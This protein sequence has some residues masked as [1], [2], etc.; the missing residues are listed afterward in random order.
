MIL[1]ASL[2]TQSS[3]AIAASIG[4]LDSPMVARGPA[5]QRYAAAGPR[6]GAN[7]SGPYGRDAGTMAA[8]CAA[9]TTAKPIAVP[10]SKNL[11]TDRIVG[12]VGS[13]VGGATCRANHCGRCRRRQLS[14][15][16]EVAVFLPSRGSEFSGK[17]NCTGHATR[18]SIFPASP[19]RACAPLTVGSPKTS[20]RPAAPS[21]PSCW[22]SAPNMS[23]AAASS[24]NSNFTFELLTDALGAA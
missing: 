23:R 1:P 24:S 10:S 14:A 17:Q 20:S 15:L 16:T 7:G 19:A 5:A 8:M 21:S 2:V 12:F 6:H 22:R 11:R 9:A 13:G 4:C 3:S 18:P